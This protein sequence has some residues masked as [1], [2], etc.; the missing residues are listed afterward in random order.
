MPKPQSSSTKYISAGI[1]SNVS[2]KTLKAMRRE[3]SEIEKADNKYSAFKKG[4]N[5]MLTIENP[6]RLETNKRFVRVPAKQV[7]NTRNRKKEETNE[8]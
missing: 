4:K 1:H 5:V 8:G 3:T 6:N 7:W 2:K